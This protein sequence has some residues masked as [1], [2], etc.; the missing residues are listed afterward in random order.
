MELNEGIRFESIPE[1][2]PIHLETGVHGPLI[3][4][5]IDN[6]QYREYPTRG[7][8]R[9][10]ETYTVG[11]SEENPEPSRHPEDREVLPS[12]RRNKDEATPTCNI[13]ALPIKKLL[14]K[15]NKHLIRKDKD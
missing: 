12:F 10:R 6:I 5:N 14:K 15:V 4:P 8:E 11:P 7:S 2:R 3:T 9:F 1:D 13:F